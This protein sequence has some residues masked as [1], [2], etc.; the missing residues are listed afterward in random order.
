MARAS[1]PTLL[2]IDRY[3]QLLGLNP[4]HLN[5]AANSGAMPYSD[6]CSDIWFQWD[7]Q[8]N[9]RTSREALALSAGAVLVTEVIDR[10]GDQG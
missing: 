10:R 7:W 6:C 3:G 4:A 9:G 8:F 1:T 5:T 2:S